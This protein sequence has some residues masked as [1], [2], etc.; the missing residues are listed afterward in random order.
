MQ[1][2]RTLNVDPAAEAAGV[3][4]TRQSKPNYGDQTSAA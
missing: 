1:L 3:L 2:G 4:K